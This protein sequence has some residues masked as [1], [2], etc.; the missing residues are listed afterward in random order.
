MALIALVFAAHAALVATPKPKPTATPDDYRARVGE[1][2]STELR[3]HSA[4]VA[5]SLECRDSAGTR[6]VLALRQEPGS[7]LVNGSALTVTFSVKS[8]SPSGTVLGDFET[9]GSI[10]SGSGGTV[11]LSATA[12]VVTGH[13]GA[14][15]ARRTVMRHGDELRRCYVLGAGDDPLPS[16]HISVYAE[17]DRTGAVRQ[18]RINNDTLRAPEVSNCAISVFKQMRFPAPGGFASVIYPIGFA[19]EDAASD[20][21]AVTGSALSQDEIRRV[22]LAKMPVIRMCYERE[23]VRDATLSGQV[24]VDFTI[25]QNGGVTA[26]SVSRSTLPNSMEACVLSSVRMLQFRRPLA[27]TVKVRYPFTFASAD[28]SS[29]QPTP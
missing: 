2:A 15:D 25:L 17:L 28:A 21:I 13:L 1:R 6:I 5:A 4:L 20:G 9:V 11:D 14:D 3:C 29:L 16:G 10:G 12:L 27:S 22:V 24:V 19:P 8:V 7:P 26:A 18:A 23:P